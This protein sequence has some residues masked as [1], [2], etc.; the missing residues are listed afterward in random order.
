MLPTVNPKQGLRIS[1]G[2][3]GDPQMVGTET[4][5]NPTEGVSIHM[6]DFRW[7]GGWVSHLAG[8]VTGDNM[9][10]AATALLQ[11]LLVGKLEGLNGL[12]QTF[13]CLQKTR[14]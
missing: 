4:W 11:K 2:S 13:P 5:P 1:S 3:W 8:C 12:L 7:I 6:Q 9:L 10:I 14:S